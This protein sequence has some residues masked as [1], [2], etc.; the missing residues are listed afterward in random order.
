MRAVRQAAGQ[1]IGDRSQPTMATQNEAQRPT[2]LL[3]HSLCHVRIAT[4]NSI[5]R[6]TF[7]EKKRP[8][9]GFDGPTE[10]WGRTSRQTERVP[11]MA[12][13]LSQVQPP[14]FSAAEASAT[15]RDRRSGQHRRRSYQL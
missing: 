5:K 7:S 1:A 8:S 9:L 10:R 12:I 3:Q 6:I 15:V 13:Q 4:T 2:G 11:V 14:G